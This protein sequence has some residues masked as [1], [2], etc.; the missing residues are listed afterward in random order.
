MEFFL[1]Y[2]VHSVRLWAKS[3]IFHSS[4]ELYD[5]FGIRILWNI[6]SFKYPVPLS[7]Q[8]HDLGNKKNFKAKIIMIISSKA[9]DWH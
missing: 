3:Q 8:I 7:Y 4:S 6:Y 2:F 9:L 1:R 5:N